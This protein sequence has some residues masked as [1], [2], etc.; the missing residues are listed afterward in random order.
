MEDM[1]VEYKIAQNEEFIYIYATFAGASNEFMEFVEAKVDNFYDANGLIFLEP[2]DDTLC[3]H[4]SKEDGISDPVNS[5]KGYIA[6]LIDRFGK[7]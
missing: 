3:M 6:D 2:V 5:V 4:F 7:K 1:K